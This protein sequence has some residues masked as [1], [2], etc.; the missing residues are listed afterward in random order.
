MGLILISRER[1][2]SQTW[3]NMVESLGLSC[4]MHLSSTGSETCF[5]AHDCLK[6]H[7]A[8]FG[9]LKTQH[10]PLSKQNLETIATENLCLWLR[11]CTV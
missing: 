9:C 10:F 8:N 5:D 6:C 3:F 2:G 11:V 7:V 4:S 1:T